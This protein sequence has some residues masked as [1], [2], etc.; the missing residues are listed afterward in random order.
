M[1]KVPTPGKVSCAEVAEF[2]KLPIEQTVKS[3]AVE[4]NGRH[5][6]LLMRGD[7]EANLVKIGKIEGLAGYRLANENELGS[8][9]KSVAGYIGPVGLG[10]DVTVIADDDPEASAA[11]ARFRDGLLAEHLGTS[12]GEIARRR[13][14]GWS[15][16]RIVDEL[17]EPWRR[18]VPI[19]DEC[20]EDEA[21]GEAPWVADFADPEAPL[22]AEHLLGALGDKPARSKKLGVA[23]GVAASLALLALGV[24]W[25]L[26]AR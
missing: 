13:N 11:I 21:A 1:K 22:D 18:L 12:P 14:E 20:S 4:A 3:I 19:E 25:M 9:F 23:T 26:G 17:G 10:K 5:F 16:V 15:L 24:A 8:V 6:L 7:H 2:L